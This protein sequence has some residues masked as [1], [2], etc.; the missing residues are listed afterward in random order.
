MDTRNMMLLVVLIFIADVLWQ[1][2][3]NR[4]RNGLLNKLSSFLAAEDYSS[5]DELIDSMK[6]RKLFPA[7]NIAFLKLNEAMMKEDKGET[8]RAFEGFSMPMNRA[9][10]EALYRKGFYYY[11]GVKEKEKANAYYHL[12]K[13]LKVNDEDTLD[14]MYDT[15][16]LDGYSYIEDVEKRIES[17]EEKQQIPYL[18]VLADMYRNKGESEKAQALEKKIGDFSRKTK[19]KQE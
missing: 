12:L 2:Y 6:V 3:Q 4:K 8:D 11:L 19:E 9:Q 18:S 5:F 10:K 15:Y 17:L 16:A 14:V 7:F 13:D 1:V